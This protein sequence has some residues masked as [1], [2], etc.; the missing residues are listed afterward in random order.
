MPS[1]K[2][3]LGQSLGS[4]LSGGG[5]SRNDGYTKGMQANA[6]AANAEESLAKAA[7]TAAEE[8]LLARQAELGTD[9]GIRNIAEI[10]SGTD[11]DLARMIEQNLRRENVPLDSLPNGVAENDF[12]PGYKGAKQ[13]ER[14]L[15]AQLMAG[16]GAGDKSVDL[17]KTL[18][19]VTE[20]VINGRLRDPQANVGAIANAL[21]AFGGKA[22]DTQ[23]G[24]AI[25][26]VNET[27]GIDPI[28]AALAAL[29]KDALGEREND[30]MQSKD[31]RYNTDVDASSSRYNTDVDA[32]TSRRNTDV[33]QNTE[34]WKHNTPGAKTGAEIGRARD[35]VRA[36]YNAEFPVGMTGARPKGAPNFAD[37]EKN[38]LRTYGINEADYYGKPAAK[39]S[40]KP[41]SVG[42]QRYLDAFARAKGNPAL[43]AKLTEMARKNGDAR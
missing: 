7:K 20:N 40:E 1:Y 31:R 28:V 15:M 22:Q 16:L 17:Q 27:P 23:Q 12:Y 43:Q 33:S 18:K 26:R 36:Q 38:W 11:N 10:S 42:R 6:Y 9:T 30:K 21:S 3:A 14:A 29:G 19:G 8:K 24:V 37:Y 32:A 5:S 13:N 25:Q 34:R 35:D 41:V 39:G 4:L 2:T